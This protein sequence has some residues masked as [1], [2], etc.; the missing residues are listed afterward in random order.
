[1]SYAQ[2]NGG[3]GSALAPRRFPG[4][5]SNWATISLRDC[6]DVSSARRFPWFVDLRL[7]IAIQLYHYR[8]QYFEDVPQ[9]HGH[10][11]LYPS[12]NTPRADGQR[13]ALICVS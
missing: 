5:W 8:I 6:D 13:G 7:S 3:R 1:M 10:H 4:P 2:G 11:L 9:H 12:N